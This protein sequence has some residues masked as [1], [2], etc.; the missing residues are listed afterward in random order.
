MALLNKTQRLLLLI[1]SRQMHM[2][3]KKNIAAAFI[4][5][6]N[7]SLSTKNNTRLHDNFPWNLQENTHLGT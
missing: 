6:H 3:S 1:L 2:I 4:K 7:K 5:M